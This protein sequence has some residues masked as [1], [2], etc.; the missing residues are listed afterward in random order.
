MKSRE[1]LEEGHAEADTLD[2]IEDA[3]PEPGC[4]REER[5]KRAGPSEV[6]A[7]AGEGPEHLAPARRAEADRKDG[8]EPRMDLGVPRQGQ[9]DKRP[10]ADEED[11]DE[12]KDGPDRDARVR[13]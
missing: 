10:D 7:D 5:A 9:E 4:D 6:V 1:R 3:K 13:P 8:Q 12:D 11:E 2:G